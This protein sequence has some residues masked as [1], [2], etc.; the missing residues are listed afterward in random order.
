MTPDS[1][2][3]AERACIFDALT[4][5]ARLRLIA[6]HE[7]GHALA[8]YYHQRMFQR[9]LLGDEGGFVD[10]GHVPFM[11]DVLFD[12]L[13]APADVRAS[14]RRQNRYKVAAAVDTLVAGSVA[15][16]RL[17]AWDPPHVSATDS[18]LM[19]SVLRHVYGEHR[20]D[21]EVHRHSA[22]GSQRMQR[23]FDAPGAWDA[24][25]GLA[26]WLAKD[27]EIGGA[28]AFSYLRERGVPFTG[29]RDYLVQ[30]GPSG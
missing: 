12:L 18:A 15:E 3:L 23:L 27:G 1:P 7:A 22:D 16:C 29:L 4:P 2:I 19:E 20:L 24:A 30:N 28:E 25:L 5:D 9:M 10:S 11:S 6:V 8:H 17:M 21:A 13:D 26:R 14:L